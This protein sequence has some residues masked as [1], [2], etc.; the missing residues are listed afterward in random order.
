MKTIWI[1]TIIIVVVIAALIVLAVIFREQL[2][3]QVAQRR[4]S[5]P[6]THEFAAERVSTD[7]VAEEQATVMSLMPQEQLSC[8]LHEEMIL[9]S[10][11]GLPKMCKARCHEGEVFA[12]ADERNENPICVKSGNLPTRRSDGSLECASH[13][14]AQLNHDGVIVGC[15]PMCNVGEFYGIDPKTNK[16]TCANIGRSADGSSTNADGTNDKTASEQSPKSPEPGE[17]SEAT[18][19]SS[20]NNT[21]VNNTTSQTSSNLTETLSGTT[22]STFTTTTGITE[23][24]TQDG[25]VLSK[26]QDPALVQ[27]VERAGTTTSETTSAPSTSGAQGNEGTTTSR[28]S[29]ARDPQVASSMEETGFKGMRTTLISLLISTIALVT[30]LAFLWYNNNERKKK[31]TIINKLYITRL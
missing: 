21:M 15:I 17:L 2:L 6:E 16:T 1:M 25:S 9:D 28:I 3:T 4:S 26:T 8:G 29:E 24:S 13:T 18:S 12:G 27:G 7:L 11:T 20:E 31:P 22:K 30:G 5:S 23:T 10:S 19:E 14:A